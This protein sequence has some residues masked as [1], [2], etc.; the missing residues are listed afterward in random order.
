VIDDDIKQFIECKEQLQ[1][2]PCTVGRALQYGQRVMSEEI[3]TQNF[4]GE[5][6][7]LLDK[8]MKNTDNNVALRALRFMLLGSGPNQ[9]R[10][11]IENHLEEF[12][13]LCIETGHK[14]TLDQLLNQRLMRLAQIALYNR[15]DKSQEI[16]NYLIK[17]GQF[18]HIN[19]EKRYQVILFNSFATKGIH[20][21]DRQSFFANDPGKC[22]L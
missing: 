15:I 5:A 17:K 18:S 12:K 16:R 22:K 3:Q 14:E 8:I 2:S 1:L 6:E 4:F 10:N 11:A 21:M 19:R 7:A 13:Q 20:Y 9:K